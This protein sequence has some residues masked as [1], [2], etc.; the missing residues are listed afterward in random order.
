[1]TDFPG[2]FLASEQDLIQDPLL[3]ALDPRERQG[4]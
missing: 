1:V 2:I 3:Y 4:L